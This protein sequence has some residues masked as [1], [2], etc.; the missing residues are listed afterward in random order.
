MPCVLTMI[1]DITERKQA[2]KELV[3]LYNATAFLFNANNVLDLGQQIVRAIVQEFGQVDCGL[4]LVDNRQQNLIRVARTGEKQIHTDKPLYLDGEGLV[5]EAVRSGQIIYA[6]DVT[7]DPRYVQSEPRTRSELVIPLRTAK[8]VIGVLDLQRDRTDA[9]SQQDQRVLSAF[10][11][12]AAAAIEIIG[13]Y[14]EINRHAADLEWNVA[15]RTVELHEA[16]ERLETIFN[17]SSDAIILIDSDG[18][19]QQINDSF[20]TMF[21][22]QADEISGS[23]LRQIITAEQADMLERAIQAVIDN[24]LERRVELVGLRKDGASFNVDVAISPV[25]EYD[26]NR[27]SVICSFRD[28]T[29]LKRLE[30]TLR[31]GLAKEKE[32]NDLKSRFT[33]MVSHEFR[34]PLS[35]IQMSSSMLSRYDDRLNPQKRIEHLNKIELQIKRMTDLLEDILTIGKTE[36]VGLAFQREVF[37]LEVFCRQLVEEIQI[38]TERHHID[39]SATGDCSEVFMGKDLMHQII[40]NTLTNAIKYSPQGGSIHFGL[41]CD[42]EQAILTVQ[43]SGV[44]IPEEDM[45]HLFETFHRARNVSDITGT[46]L[47]LAIVKR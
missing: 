46:G 21:R 43:D 8:G 18:A 30:E 26:S 29:E 1:H 16:K 19:I 5:P 24:K 37:D 7:T 38:T 40:S 28:I 6:P 36:A 35:I 10:A 9:F 11:E 25:T 13:L 32:L 41:A 22:Y 44:G 33:S 14:E 42:S 4:I 23:F 20:S 17:N 47:G 45:E 2:E 34:T 31:L 3:A 39:F 27:T 15:R 12:R